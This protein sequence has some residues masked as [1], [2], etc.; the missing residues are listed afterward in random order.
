MRKSLHVLIAVVAFALMGSIVFAYAPVVKPLPDV[1]IGDAEDNVGTVDLNMFR[2]SNAFNLDDYVSDQDSTISEL[3]WSFYEGGPPN[4]VEIN[5]IYQ[6]DDPADAINADTLGKDIRHAAAPFDDAMVDFW[7][8]KDSPRGSGPPWP[9]PTSPLNEIITLFVSDGLYVDSG[10]MKVEAVDDGN[11]AISATTVWEFVDGWDFEGDQDGWAFVT[12]AT[13]VYDQQFATATSN[14][15]GNAIGVT[16]DNATSRYG[17]WYGPTVAYEAGK[18]YKY[19]WNVSTGQTVQD[20]VP[21][22]RLRVGDVAASYVQTMT[23]SSDGVTN[24]NEPTPTGKVYNQYLVPLAAGDM[25]PNYD[26]YDF[27]PDP[28]GDIGTVWLEELNVYKTDE[29]ASGWTAET[30]PALSTWVSVNGPGVYNN[31]T[32]GSSGGLQLGSSLS[33]DRGYGFWGILDSGIAF[34]ADTMYRAIFS[35]SSSDAGPLPQGMVRVNSTDLQVA[36][37]LTFYDAVGPT[38]GGVDYPL[39]FESHTTRP[40]PADT[41]G[42]YFELGDFSTGESGTMTLTGVTVESMP[43]LP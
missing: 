29:P 41:F 8:E 39:Y 10:Q 20:L 4:N 14:F 30:V 6:L 33:E 2:F 40:A 19:A 31:V 26:V 9:D 21:T 23:L 35:V 43:V 16:T 27:S 32:T 38:S 24:P 3:V 11:D 17:F 34:Q 28:G 15:N 22:V 13:N 18:L 1:Y 36:Y 42:L 25:R 37:R 12:F 5:G 7:D